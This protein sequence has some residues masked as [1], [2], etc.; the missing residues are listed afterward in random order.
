MKS[1]EA[2]RT[3]PP[4]LEEAIGADFERIAAAHISRL[5]GTYMSSMSSR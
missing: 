4:V 1:D 2:G 3:D 5:P